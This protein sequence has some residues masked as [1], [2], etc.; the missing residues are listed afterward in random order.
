[1]WHRV[2][3]MY[4]QIVNQ[5][6]CTYYIYIH[7]FTL[8][9]FSLDESTF[10]ILMNSWRKYL[11]VHVDSSCIHLGTISYQFES[12]FNNPEVQPQWRE[13]WTA[14]EE[15]LKTRCQNYG[16]PLWALAVSTPTSSRWYSN[17]TKPAWSIS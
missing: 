17:G 16:K 7:L 2:N 6:T 13:A 10:W 5:L 4:D 1:M 3:I 11:F 15:A 12:F 14:K 8:H 9:L